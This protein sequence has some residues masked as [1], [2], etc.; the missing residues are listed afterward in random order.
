MKPADKGIEIVSG[1]IEPNTK[2]QPRTKKIT[3]INE[4]ENEI[5]VSQEEIEPEIKPKKNK[6]PPKVKI[7]NKNVRNEQGYK[8][9]KTG[10]VDKRSI[11]GKERI[12][13]VR[14]ALERAKQAKMQTVSVDESDSDDDTYEYEVKIQDVKQIETPAP[15][16]AP[17]SIP[18]T[19]VEQTK[20]ELEL[21][22]I[23][24]SK[25]KQQYSFNEHLNRISNMSR[26][27]K[28]KF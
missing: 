18:D 21:L 17:V 24:N 5:V 9:T 8:L 2:K 13:K 25:L 7:I 4:T 20:A 27:I 14:E 12:T 16:P 10:N 6:V 26:S 3:K 23:E 15:T 19:V 22:K 11:N 1:D 28:M